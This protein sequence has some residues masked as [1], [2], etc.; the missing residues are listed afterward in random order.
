MKDIPA[1]VLR[2]TRLEHGDKAAAMRAYMAVSTA[3][4]LLAM[5]LIP[6]LAENAGV[7]TVVIACGVSQI[8]VGAFGL[9]RH[10]TWRE[11]AA[12]QAQ[13]T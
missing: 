8:G 13:S 3:G 10:A 6:A 5:L 4:T 9:A 2:Q 1:A 7:V 11:P 12:I